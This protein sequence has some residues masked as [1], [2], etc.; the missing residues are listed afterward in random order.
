ML[1]LSLVVFLIINMA[2]DFLHTGQSSENRDAPPLN[3]LAHRTWIILSD[4]TV[5]A[6]LS[7]IGYVLLGSLFGSNFQELTLPAVGMSIGSV[8]G[9]LIKLPTSQA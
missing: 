4:T 3:R 6:C 5:K 1:L 7:F 9:Q 2:M 8:G